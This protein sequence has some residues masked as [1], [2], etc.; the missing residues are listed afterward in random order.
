[1]SLTS[2]TLTCPCSQS[3]WLTVSTTDGG[4]GFLNLERHDMSRLRGIL[5]SDGRALVHPPLRRRLRF[6]HRRPET[7]R[8]SF[9]RRLNALVSSTY[10]IRRM[11]PWY[12]VQTDQNTT[13]CFR[14]Y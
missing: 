6:R 9:R 12:F 5:L 13:T 3:L 7:T 1:M 4:M 11:R 14:L 8:M 10:P 2:L